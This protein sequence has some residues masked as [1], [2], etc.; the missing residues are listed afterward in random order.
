M[1]SI[2]DMDDIRK[3][4][5]KR[6][7]ELRKSK[8]YTQEV[9]AERMQIDTSA[10]GRIEIGKRFPA[11]ETI[12]KLCDALEIPYSVLFTFEHIKMPP[13]KNVIEEVNRAMLEDEEFAQK[14]Y[15]VYRNLKA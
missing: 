6:V 10:L 3:L 2:Y 11:P 4:I 1:V 13:I 9:L 14:M 8:G 5:G 15:I 12:D 7:K